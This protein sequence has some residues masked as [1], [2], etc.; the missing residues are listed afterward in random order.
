MAVG[1][2]T[3]QNVLA[4]AE[5]IKIGGIQQILLRHFEVLLFA[6]NFVSVEAIFAQGI[7]LVGCSSRVRVKISVKGS[8]RHAA[9]RAPRGMLE[10]RQCGCD[11]GELVRV[12]KAHHVFVVVVGREAG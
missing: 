12:Q 4:T 9:E 5:G 10:R 2:S 6:G 7:R 3:R 1:V 11:S 8:G